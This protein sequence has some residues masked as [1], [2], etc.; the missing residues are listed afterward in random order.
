MNWPLFVQ[1]SVTA[2]V[3]F[4]GAFLAHALSSRR[5]RTNKKRDQRISFLIEAYRRL[6]F[7]SNRPEIEDSKPVESAMADI[8]LF[9]SPNLVRLSQEFIRE[10]AKHRTA[11]LDPLLEA[12][13]ADLRE[14]LELEP[15]PGKLLFLRWSKTKNE[16]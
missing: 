5:D 2:C 1:L 13:R 3:A 12:L 10:F 11:S 7:V 8:Q 16:T 15:S 14:E 4:V 9:G 6:E